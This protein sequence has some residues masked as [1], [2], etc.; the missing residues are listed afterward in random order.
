MITPRS[1]FDYDLVTRERSL[2]KQQ[3]VLGGYDPTQYVS[4]RIHATAEDGTQIP[5]SLV[6]RRETFPAT[7]RPHSFCTDTAATGFPF[8]PPSVRI[9]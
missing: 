4:E 5:I 7:G 6:Y 2:R 9:V 8:P 3:P 1:V